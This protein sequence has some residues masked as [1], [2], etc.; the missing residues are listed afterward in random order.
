[1]KLPYR[2]IWWFWSGVGIAYYTGHRDR[3]DIRTVVYKWFP[4][5]RRIK[6]S[7]P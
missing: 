7:G 3:I 2:S 5:P 6:G 4:Y 1:M